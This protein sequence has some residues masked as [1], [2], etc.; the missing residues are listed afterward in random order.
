MLTTT[1]S[2]M[3]LNQLRVIDDLAAPDKAARLRGILAQLKQ[4][5]AHGQVMQPS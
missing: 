3:Q 1:S 5:L 2:L 4:S